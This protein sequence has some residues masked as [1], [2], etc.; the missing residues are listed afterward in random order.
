MVGCLQFIKEIS[1]SGGIPYIFIPLSFIIALSAAKDLFE[2]YKRHH[3]DDEENNRK[4]K[5]YK[6]GQFVETR[7]QDLI[8][9]DIIKVDRF[10]D[11]K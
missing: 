3:S 10:F 2:D 4:T 5:V 11:N 7:W 8:V 1:T 6:N 9:G